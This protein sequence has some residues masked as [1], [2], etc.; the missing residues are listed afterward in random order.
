MQLF[1]KLHKIRVLINVKQFMFIL[2]SAHGLP[3][4]IGNIDRTSESGILLYTDP[5]RV[6]HRA[7]R[8]I[9][10]PPTFSKSQINYTIQPIL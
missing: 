1:E 2:G 3:G 8:P 4:R 5:R 9:P 10:T 6:N 7:V